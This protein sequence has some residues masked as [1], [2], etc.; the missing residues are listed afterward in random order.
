MNV[1]SRLQNTVNCLEFM[2]ESILE[3]LWRILRIL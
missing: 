2:R 1:G 3:A